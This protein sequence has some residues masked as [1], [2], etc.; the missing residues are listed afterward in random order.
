MNKAP[1]IF[2]L[3][4]AL[5]CIDLGKWGIS[6]HKVYVKRDDLIHHQV[7]GNKW[8]KLKHNINYF[9]AGS[10]K[11]I[12]TLGGAHSNHILAA[13]FLGD[14]YNIPLTLL[15]R[16]EQP[17]HL[18]PT[19]KKCKELGAALLFFSRKEYSS[20]VENS[21][22]LKERWPNS[23]IIPEGGANQMGIL[24]CE[25][26]VDEIDVDYDEIYCDVGT[27][28]TLAGISNK[29]VSHQ[30]VK[31]VVVLKGAEY[32]HDQ[33]LEL[34]ANNQKEN[35]SLLHDYHFG[36]YAKN[37]SLLLKFMR[38]FY[39]NTGI[40]TDPIYSGK[41]FYGLIDQ[42]KKQ[43]IPKTIVALHS[44]GVQGNVGFEQRYKLK[45]FA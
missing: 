11:G 32:L 6:N 24:G 40:K 37:N 33:V 15:I 7:A 4:S 34:K 21:T 45:I 30:L 14:F 43:T 5:Q 17:T 2:K 39:E 36:G 13:A 20:M 38:D 22:K 26:I 41:M 23:L 1:D 9:L 29:L 44:G 31:G 3:P 10:Y 12:V 19:L 42:L 28:A 8:R 35:F 25:D 18:S 16:G 27:G